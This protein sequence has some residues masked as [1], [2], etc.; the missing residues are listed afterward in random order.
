M[1]KKKIDTDVPI[2]IAGIT[3]IP[4]TEAILNCW[5]VTKGISFF[6]IKRPLGVIMI[7]PSGRKAFRTSGEEIPLEQF[8]QE[9]PGIKE[10]LDDYH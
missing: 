3:L 6:G 9:V 10:V 2:T 7:S 4:V 5:P 8:I 1:E